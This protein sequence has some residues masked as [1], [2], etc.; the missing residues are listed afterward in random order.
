MQQFRGRLAATLCECSLCLSVAF[1]LGCA[2]GFSSSAT[3]TAQPSTGTATLSWTRPTTNTNG[4]L[5]LNLA[6]YRIDYGARPDALKQSIT[7]F[8]P[9]T[10]SYTLQGLASGTWYFAISAFTTAGTSSTLSAVVSK[11]IQ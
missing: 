3:V 4:S 10:T 7:V 1:A 2:G 5:L 6:G 9:A 8:D 11:T